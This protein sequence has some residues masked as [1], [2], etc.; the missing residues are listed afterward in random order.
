MPPR[1]FSPPVTSVQ[2]K[3]TE[4]SIAD[5]ASVSKEKYTPRRRRIRKPNTAASA[6]TTSNPVASGKTN[7][8]G[9]HARC[10]RPAAYAASPNH[11]PWPNETRPVY[12]T[13]IL[14]AMQAM[15]KTTTSVA[16]VTPRPIEVRANGSTIS[17]IA[18][19]IR[20]R[21]C[22]IGSNALFESLDAFAEQPARPH[23]QDD[24]HQQIDRGL[25]VL[26]IAGGGHEAFGETDDH[27]RH[28][29]APER[30]EATDDDDHE[31]RGDDLRAH[32]GVDRE[33]RRQH[34]PGKSG[35]TDAEESDRGHVGLQRDAERADHVRVLHAGANHTSERRL[36][37]QEPQSGDAQRSDCNDQ[38]AIV[39]INEV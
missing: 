10:A 38:R 30:T 39:G 17:A 14:S 8:P 4:Y 33:D 20:S 15:A 7:E 31:G 37:Q 36:L 35:E 12:P 19:M 34:H 24:K 32:R 6:I 29:D 21:I 18:A 9:N 28:H 23:E 25:G 5:S 1:P 11:A 2:R 26:R 22:G 13:K 3:A 16:E 27:G